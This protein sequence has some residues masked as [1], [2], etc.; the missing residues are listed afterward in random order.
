MSATASVLDSATSEMVKH[1]P[2]P[3]I[4][5]DNALP[6][7]VYQR[8]ADTYPDPELMQEDR[9]RQNNRRYDLLSKWGATE[10]PYENASDEW[11]AFTDTHTSKAFV[12]S[13][14][15]LFPDCLSQVDG[16]PKIDIS[17][18]GPNLSQKIKIGSTVGFDEIVPRVT[19]A[20]NTPVKEVSSVRGAHTDAIRKAYV[21]LLYFRLPEDDSTGGDL[22]IFKWK[23]GVKQEDWA[24]KVDRRKVDLLETIEYKPNRL[25]L[26]QT[27]SNAL[28]GVSPR[29]A[30]PYWRRLVVISGWLPGVDHYDTDTMHGRLAGLKASA[31]A[32]ARR[33]I[34]R[35]RA[36]RTDGR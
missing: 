26:F 31:L 6:E 23:D 1:D 5:V 14:F 12:Q 20:V 32:I 8:L 21:G 35:A 24:V 10:F 2:F 30:T 22:E 18:F 11:K 16:Q 13:V 29:S 17:R 25:I 28:H 36:K 4:V 3:Y 7:D 9:K 34:G 27:T 33:A 19:V 15:G